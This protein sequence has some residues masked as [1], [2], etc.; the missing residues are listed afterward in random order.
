[1][2]AREVDRVI[3]RLAMLAS[4]AKPYDAYCGVCFDIERSIGLK[5]E[6]LLC[7]AWRA[8]GL[9]P[10]Q[11]IGPYYAQYSLEP[12]WKGHLGR[13]RRDLCKRTVFHLVR[14]HGYQGDWA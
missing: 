14:V 12:A 8:M 7:H 5:E 13:K 10:I 2:S 11:P 9:H 6:R 4:G 1:M 3:E